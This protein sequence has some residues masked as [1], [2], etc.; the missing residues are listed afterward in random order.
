MCWQ[1]APR[2]IPSLLHLP[3]QLLLRCGRPVP[4]TF[5]QRE[6]QQLHQRAHALRVHKHPA[7]IPLQCSLLLEADQQLSFAGLQ[8]TGE[9]QSAPQST[10]GQ[11]RERYKSELGNGHQQGRAACRPPPS[12]TVLV[13]GVQAVL[14]IGLSIR[15]PAG[16]CV[17]Q[18]VC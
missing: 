3:F 2:I 7:A 9:W 4:P 5:R 12:S 13:G 14:Q 17:A 6:L 1:C 16:Q 11:C 18:Q 15:R 10:D 8:K